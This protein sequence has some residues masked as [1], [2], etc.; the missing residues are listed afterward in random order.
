MQQALGVNAQLLMKSPSKIKNNNKNEKEKYDIF[1]LPNLP[2]GKEHKKDQEYTDSSTSSFSE[3]SENDSSFKDSNPWREYNASIQTIDVRSEHF[4]SLPPEVRHE[5]LVDIKDTR[6]QSSW[7]RLHELPSRSNEFSS[8]QMKRLLK[9][10]AVQESIEETEKEM[11][12]RA[13]TFTDLQ[14]LFTEEG[15]LDP[16][17]IHQSIYSKVGSCLIQFLKCNNFRRKKSMLR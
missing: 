9:R 7:G 8:F 15:I 4:K 11:G 3:V 14:N 5:I 13:L 12:K 10:R 17:N 16:E 6:K 2:A 1:K